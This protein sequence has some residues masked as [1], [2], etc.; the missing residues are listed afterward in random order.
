MQSDQLAFSAEK[1]ASYSSEGFELF[2]K[3][4]SNPELFFQ[5]G[6]KYD[7]SYKSMYGDYVFAGASPEEYLRNLGI[8]TSSM[9]EAKGERYVKES[10]ERLIKI[11]HESLTIS[12]ECYVKAL[13]IDPNHYYANLYLATALTAALQVEA[14][15]PYWVK[16]LSLD[17]RPTYN[18]LIADSE[19][20]NNKGVA[21]RLVTNSLG[22]GQLRFSNLLDNDQTKLIGEIVI[23]STQAIAM[24][25]SSDQGFYEQHTSNT[26]FEQKE[27]ANKLLTS[28][29]LLCKEIKY[30]DKSKAKKIYEYEESEQTNYSNPITQKTHQSATNSSL[31]NYSE[32]EHSYRE[33]KETKVIRPILIT[34]FI[35]SLIVSI[36]IGSLEPILMFL[37]GLVVFILIVAGLL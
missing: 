25:N 35:A 33:Q 28:S 31:D 7:Y 14:A 36:M 12:C 34:L 19:G 10:G 4:L 15:I 9:R 11:G 8:P 29:P 22:L 20:P 32:V 5:A 2:Q 27:L 37:F 18:N 21:T 16:S 1:M 13:Q 23:K 24:L 6:N 26:Y 30:L 17:F 3:A